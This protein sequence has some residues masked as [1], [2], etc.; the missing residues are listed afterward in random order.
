MNLRGKTSSRPE[1]GRDFLYTPIYQM[2]KKRKFLKLNKAHL[3]LKS[4]STK[5]F[6]K[7]PHKKLENKSCQMLNFPIF[8]KHFLL[9]PFSFIKLW[10]IN[11][12]IL[13]NTVYDC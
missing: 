6:L 10:T 8:V 7:S 13:Q 9:G 12:I 2:K 1:T 3:R 4:W 5:D 11:N